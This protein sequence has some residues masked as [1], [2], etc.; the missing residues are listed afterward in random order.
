M[1]TLIRA[2]TAHD[3]EWIYRFVCELATYEREPG[4]VVTTPQRIFA[5]LSMEHPPFECLI[6]ERGGAPVGMALFY[7]NYSTWRGTPGLYLEDLY[8]AEQS[9]RHGVGRALLVELARLCKRR[10]YARMDWAVLSWNQLGVHFYETLG[11]ARLPEWNLFRLT[12]EAL[13]ALGA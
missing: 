12:G 11:A 1:S 5:Q 6:A 10:G 13:D 3:A 4:A 2:A 7:Q 8:V 9:R